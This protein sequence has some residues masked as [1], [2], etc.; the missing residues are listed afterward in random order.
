MII[1]PR[2][3]SELSNYTLPQQLV[4]SIVKVIFQKEVIY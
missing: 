1:F 3:A 2:Q 4:V